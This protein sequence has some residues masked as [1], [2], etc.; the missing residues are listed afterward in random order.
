VDRASINASIVIIGAGVVGCAIAAAAARKWR[1]VVILDS[2]PIPGMATSA[3]SSGVIHSGINY[4][5]GSLKARHCVRGS[6]LTYEFCREHNIPHRRTGKLVVATREAEISQLPALLTRGAEN[7]VAGLRIVDRVRI[8]ELEPNV[9]GVAALEIPSTGIVSTRDLVEAYIR[10]AQECGAR[11]SA[12]ESV[13]GLEPISQ[14]IRVTTSAGEFVTRCL[15]NSAGLRAPEIAA[16]L[17]SPLASHRIYP[18]RGDYADVIPSRRK[19]VRGLVY[20]VPPAAGLSLGVHLT[21][22][23]RGSLLI[24][25]TALPIARIDDYDSPVPSMEEFAALAAPLLPSITAADLIPSYFGIRPRLTPPD[26][27]RFSDFVIERD[28]AI[29]AAIQLLGIES[30]GLTAAPS[31]AEQVAAIA[32]KILG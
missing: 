4:Q 16:L 6:A 28:P 11:L 19:L 25:P 12:G 3:R 8:R 2:L 17:G 5:P 32:E 20:P 24:G 15:I 27:P 1:D 23:I 13:T 9:A 22:T 21:R 18:V 14:V 30:P 26:D 7:G 31:I 10:V 29:P